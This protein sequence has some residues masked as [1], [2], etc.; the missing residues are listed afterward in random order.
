[1]ARWCSC[2]IRG[3]GRPH[4]PGVGD[5]ALGRGAGGAAAALRLAQTR[6]SGSAHPSNNGTKKLAL[7]RRWED[8]ETMLRNAGFQAKL[9]LYLAGLLTGVALAL[10]TGGHPTESSFFHNQDLQLFWRLYALAKFKS[11]A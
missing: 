6:S 9:K 4:R 1:M 3:C 7:H 10:W 2:R 8:N 11:F 5:D